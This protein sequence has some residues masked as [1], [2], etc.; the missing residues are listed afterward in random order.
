MIINPKYIA[1]TVFLTTG[2]FAFLLAGVALWWIWLVVLGLYT[3]I[4]IA[5]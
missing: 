3:L 4:A 5:V 1:I 2:L